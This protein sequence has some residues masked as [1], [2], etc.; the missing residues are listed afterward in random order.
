MF[1]GFQME[2]NQ[3]MA[4]AVTQTSNTEENTKMDFTV[5]SQ[6]VTQVRS[7]VAELEEAHGGVVGTARRFAKEWHRAQKAGLTQLAFFRL[8]YTELPESFAGLGVS[9]VTKKYKMY[10]HLMYLIKIGEPAASGG[11]PQKKVKVTS[12]M[13]KK[14]TA[15]YQK[16]FVA[17]G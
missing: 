3:G 14:E 6:F 13:R 11:K 8:F 15:A 2:A 17:W 16:S 1:T 5:R 9:A 4:T 10:N 12:E 7:A